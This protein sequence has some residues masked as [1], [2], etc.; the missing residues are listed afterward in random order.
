MFKEMRRK[1][2]QLSKSEAEEVLRRCSSGV[3]AVHGNDGYPY[4]V[5]LSYSYENGEVYF[6]CALEGHKL[7]AIREN[8]KVSFC[9]IDRDEVSPSEFTTVYRSVIV[10]GK[11]EIV[12]DEGER[13]QA[14]R[15]LI[16]K[17]SKGYE[18]EGEI[19][20][21]NTGKM[22]G[23]VKITIDHITGK[24]EKRLIK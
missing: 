9:V 4:G 16:D 20:I 17:Y 13:M 21:K 2:Q 1:N 5:P 18:K 24:A 22:A 23:I 3:L 11:A 7:D 8:E 19:E 6:H 14:F 12:S 15:S 10:F